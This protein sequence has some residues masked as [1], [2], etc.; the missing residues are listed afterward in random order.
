MQ[1]IRIRTGSFLSVIN[2]VATCALT[3]SSFRESL[4]GNPFGLTSKSQ[5]RKT[6]QK[7]ISQIVPNRF[8][9]SIRPLTL[10]GC[11]KNERIFNRKLIAIWKFIICRL[12]R[13]KRGNNNQIKCV[14]EKAL[15]WI[16]RGVYNLPDFNVII[17]WLERLFKSE[18]VYVS[19]SMSR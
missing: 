5:I 13:T 11:Y 6:H 14:L 12:R 2:I 17:I 16:L 3:Q 1:V 9:R 7:I 4:A 19:I 10:I 15:W 18:S 8:S